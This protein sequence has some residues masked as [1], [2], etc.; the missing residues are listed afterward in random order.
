MTGDLLVAGFTC[1]GIGVLADL[2]GGVGTLVVRRLPYLAALAASAIFLAVGVRALSGPTTTV[3]LAG[4]AAWNGAHLR[5]DHLSGFF[6]VLTSTLGALVSL[7]THS[8]VESAERVHR[9]GTAA[10]YLLLLGAVTA[11]LLA[12]DAFSFLFAWESLTLSFYF[13]TAVDRHSRGQARAAWLTATFGKVGG[14]TLLIAMLL[15]SSRA[16]S[17]SLEAWRHVAPGALRDV[18]WVLVVIGF[19]AKIGLVPLQPWL[20]VG[21]P[22]APAPVRAALGGVAVNVGVYGLWRFLSVLG[23]PPVWLVIVVLLAGGVTALLGITFAVVQGR[24]SR[25]IAYSSVENAG[26][27]VTAYGVAL[28]GAVVG[29]PQLEAVGLLA[30][31]LQTVAHAIAKTSL[32]VSLAHVEA[33]LGTDDLDEI[34]GVGRRMPWSGAAL[35]AGALTLAGLPPTIGFVSEWFVLEALMQQFRLAGLAL[36]L[37]LAAAGALVALTT[38]LAALTFLRVLGLAVL[39]APTERVRMRARETGLAGRAALVALTVGCGGLAAASPWEVHLL[40]RG[41][42]PVVASSVVGQSLKSP[43]VLQPVFSNFSILSP[44]WLWVVLPL[45]ALLTTVLAT[46]LSGGRMWRTRRVR[47]WHSASPGVQGPSHYTAFAFANPVRHVLANVLG[48]S[49]RT[50]K[51]SAESR[52]SRSEPEHVEIFTEV[53]EPVE[54]YLFAPLARVARALSRGATRLQSGRLNT[55]VAYMLVALLVTLVLSAAFR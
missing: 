25:V 8:W 53:I 52:R 18:S 28:T 15:L 13:L 31:T 48:T 7:S 49:R 26:L 19:G 2:F 16:G 4:L 44:S 45:A 41:L 42:S 5:A 38:G 11:I 54:T 21:Y 33:A 1:L 27:I 6:L 34:R 47:A 12:G 24:L 36:R 23:R 9:R 3:D 43:W 10:G 29:S 35:G 32:F 20:T 39:G 17:T 40:E 30:G 55:Y 37:A 50:A 22:A 51:L 46:V 14:A